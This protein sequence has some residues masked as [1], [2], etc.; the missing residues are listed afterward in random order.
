MHAVGSRSHPTLHDL[1]QGLEVIGTR[2]PLSKSIQGIAYHSAAVE[3]D[4]LFV[5]IRGTHRDGHGF[6][7]DALERGASAAVVE[8][9]MDELPSGFTQI[10]VPEARGALAQLA[11]TYYVYPARNLILVGITGTNGKTTTAHI[12]EAI[13]NAAGHRVGVL[14]T[15]QYRYGDR[16]LPASTTTPESLD[17]QEILREMVDG[18]ITHVIMEVTSHALAQNRVLGCHFQGA[19]FTN[20]SRDHLDYHGTMEAYLAAKIL[21][22]QEHLLP[23]AQGGWAVIN[24]RDPASRE[25]MNHCQGRILRFGDDSQADFQVLEWTSNLDGIRMAIRH[26]D[27][28]VALSSALLGEPNVFNILAACGS[29]WTLGIEPEHW[30]AGLAALPTVRGRF[31]PVCNDRGMTL[32]VDYAHTPDALHRALGTARRL[33]SGRLICVF[34]CGGDRDQGKRAIMAKA[35]ARH[36]DIVV[37]TS[38]NPRD[39]PPFAIIDQIVS[40]FNG[41]PI[42]RVDPS[43]ETGELNLPAYTILEDRG[44]AIRW[45]IH[46]AKPGDLVFIAGKGHETHQIVGARRI[47]LDD[48]EVAKRA[49]EEV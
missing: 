40:G 4:F 46:R 36:S 18:G 30:R 24:A 42:V 20:L 16:T 15:I 7:K 41:V 25:I 11:S 38:D 44:E 22:F 9:L 37:V 32:V 1:L 8:R 19:V 33:I 35:A 39:E 27:G 48:R 12:L 5:A 13:L 28:E 14:G 45:A 6:L 49:L 43:H 31:E 23:V 34:G 47:P 26:P 29:A 21:L 3:K 10:Q 17:L 2:G